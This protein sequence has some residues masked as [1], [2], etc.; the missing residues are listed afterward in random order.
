MV[1][2]NQTPCV[3]KAPRSAMVKTFYG[4]Y[5]LQRQLKNE[6]K[7][8]RNKTVIAVNYTKQEGVFWKSYTITT[9]NRKTSLLTINLL[10][11]TFKLC[12][13]KRG[14]LP[15]KLILLIKKNNFYLKKNQCRFPK[16]LLKL[17]TYK[18]KDKTWTQY[19]IQ[20]ESTGHVV[21]LSY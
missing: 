11:T 18:M 4:T 21:Q 16:M 12:F 6:W 8:I 3:T 17:V 20:D 1:R 14:R 19:K 2:S 15:I 7:N 5:T 10:T 9:F 13:L